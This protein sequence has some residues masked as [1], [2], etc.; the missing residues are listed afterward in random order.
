MGTISYRADVKDKDG[1]AYGFP[2][3]YE[4]NSAYSAD[5][6]VATWHTV[7]FNLC[8][9]DGLGEIMT[10]QNKPTCW[11]RVSAY[12]TSNNARITNSSRKFSYVM[13]DQFPPYLEVKNTSNFIFEAGTRIFLEVVL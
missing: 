3:G 4:S 8:F 11:A 6:N 7:S 2:I 5:Y 10:I 12:N 9:D 1:R 13:N